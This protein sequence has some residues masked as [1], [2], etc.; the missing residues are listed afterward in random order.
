MSLPL[1]DRTLVPRSR[2]PERILQFG[3][4]N[5][6]RGFADWVVHEMNEKL[7][8]NAGVVVVQ[9][10]SQTGVR[11]YNAQEGLYTLMLTGMQDGTAKQEITV[12]DC[13]Q[14]ALSATYDFEDF[15][16]L[17]RSESIEV[18]LS[19]TTENGI[20]FDKN[21]A[22]TD[23]PPGSFPGKLTRL[24][25]ERYL[26]FS[27]QQDKGWVI[28]PCE[29]IEDNGTRLKHIVLQLAET[30][31]LPDGF[32]QWLEASCTFCNTLVDR[33]VSGY[34]NNAAEIQ[35]KLG[36]T[37]ELLTEGESFYL[38]VI[39]ASP[40]VQKVFP[41]DQAGLQ[42]V[43]ASDIHPYRVRK[44]RILNGAHTA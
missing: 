19:N 17:A 22:L 10:V 8:F 24:L 16:A 2:R 38:W 36:Y 6:L 9:S 23:V 3:G 34:P 39:T 27:G 40:A 41:A 11:Q 18:V 25:Y 21:D 37:D 44:V 20:V 42:V 30:W 43:F 4:G 29:L 15:L 13:I 28:I 35:A 33:I 26:F 14:R 7:D 5:F 31:Q 1:L 12:V 32:Q